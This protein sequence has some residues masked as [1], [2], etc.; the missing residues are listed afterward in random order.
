VRQMLHAAEADRSVP[1]RPRHRVE[2]NLDHL[3][4]DPSSWSDQRLSEAEGDDWDPGFCEAWP[5]TRLGDLV[6]VSGELDGFDASWSTL[7]GRRSNESAVPATSLSAVP[8][9]SSW[10][11]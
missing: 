2:P 9:P 4:S 8:T 1:D 5:A 6:A 10:W 3:S 7:A 11:R